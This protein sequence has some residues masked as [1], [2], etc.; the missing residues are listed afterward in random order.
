M[1]DVD[2]DRPQGDAHLCPRPARRLDPRTPLVETSAAVGRDPPEVVLGFVGMVLE[3]T[4]DDGEGQGRAQVSTHSR[5]ACCSSGRGI[6]PGPPDVLLGFGAAAAP[7]RVHEHHQRLGRALRDGALHTTEHRRR[8]A[9]PEPVE[10]LGRRWPEPGE[11]PVEVEEAEVLVSQ[12]GGVLEGRTVGEGVD[13]LP[14]LGPELL[15]QRNDVGR[16]HENVGVGVAAPVAQGRIEGR[17]LDVQHI[18]AAGV[19]DPLH[20]S[21]GKADP[22]VERKQDRRKVARRRGSRE[23]TTAPPR[24]PPPGLPWCL[25]PYDCRSTGRSHPSS[26]VRSGPAASTRLR[27]GWGRSGGR[28]GPWR[29]DLALWAGVTAGALGLLFVAIAVVSTRTAPGITLDTWLRDLVNNG[30]PPDM[31]ESLNELARPRIMLVLA[32]AVV[33]LTLLAAAPPPL[34]PGVRCRGRRH[35][36][37]P[38]RVRRSIS[39]GHRGAG[40]RLPIEP[41]HRSGSPCSSPSCWRGPCAS[42]AGALFTTA[43]VAICIL[44]G[45][46]SWHA[47]TPRDVAGSVLLVAAVTAMTLA[48][49]GTEAAN[50][51]LR[52]AS[53]RPR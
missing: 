51:R 47:H 11:D 8:S 29:R 27:L 37:A 28:R 16:P 22:H 9:R 41:R 6:G 32:P 18:G 33:V 21:M 1:L 14:P 46:V 53:S 13:Q 2:E 19:G 26:P 43:V 3:L 34:A 12:G 39:G 25:P 35:R 4:R 52:P 49:L 50:V 36:G 44:V 20:R 17:A 30:M 10:G 45:N 24:G 15:E 23:P 5:T 31:R 38:A 7:G 42:S 48:L 40:R